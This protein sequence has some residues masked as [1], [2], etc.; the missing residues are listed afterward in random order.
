[1]G[2]TVVNKEN[3]GSRRADYLDWLRGGEFVSCAGR[4]EAKQRGILAAGRS[5][6]APAPLDIGS[7]LSLPMSS[8]FQ[9]A[10]L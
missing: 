3:S 6:H 8:I 5:G 4:Q 10:R 2:N 7:P 1:M 9:I